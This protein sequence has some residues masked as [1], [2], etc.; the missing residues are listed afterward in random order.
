MES[1]QI[2]PA[3]KE[4]LNFASK[5][6]SITQ[7]VMAVLAV[8]LLTT[9]LFGGYDMAI[10]LVP[11][12]LILFLITGIVDMYTKSHA[13]GSS[14]S[15]YGKVT[16]YIVETKPD[17]TVITKTHVLDAQV[18]QVDPNK[19]MKTVIKVTLA[20]LVIVPLIPYILGI[21]FLIVLFALGGTGGGKSG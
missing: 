15:Q 2:N 18:A 10:K 3:P 13:G 9:I 17:G 11:V 6:V 19:K 1:T 20:L 21:G 4:E 14:S 7:S 8:L 12:A 5:K 16:E